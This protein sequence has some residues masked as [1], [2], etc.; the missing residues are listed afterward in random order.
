MVLLIILHVT[1][2]SKETDCNLPPE[3]SF[4]PISQAS[5]RNTTFDYRIQCSINDSTN[6]NLPPLIASNQ[7]SKCL[8]SNQLTNC[9]QLL[10]KDMVMLKHINLTN[11]I[12]YMNNFNV[13]YILFIYKLKMEFI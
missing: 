10:F 13:I 6:L 3:C 8:L 2:G 9:F 11:I 1:I 5:D 12:D 7:K 4:K